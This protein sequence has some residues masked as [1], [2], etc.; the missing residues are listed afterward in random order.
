MG[1]IE[2]FSSLRRDPPG[3]SL[4]SWALKNFSSGS[5]GFKS[6]RQGKKHAEKWR[7]AFSAVVM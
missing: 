7:L 1:Q 5:S 4:I 2:V 6:P 3:A